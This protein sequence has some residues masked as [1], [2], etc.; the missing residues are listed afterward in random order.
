MGRKTSIEFSAR[1]S[2]VGIPS[3]RYDECP[4]GSTTT[5]LTAVDVGKV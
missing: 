2:T 1:N 3:E 5:P 4:N